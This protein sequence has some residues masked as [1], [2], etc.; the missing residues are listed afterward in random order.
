MKI[1]VQAG[2][3]GTRMKHLAETKPKSLIAAKYLPIVFH[4]FERFRGDEFV[5]VGDYKFD[6]FDNYLATFAENVKCILVKAQTKGNAA[7]LKEAVALVPPN[8]PFMVI[9]SDIIL[10][11][12]FTVRDIKKGCQVGVADFPCSWSLIDGR[13][14]HEQH[15]SKGVAGLYLFDDKGWFDDFPDGG[16]FTDW[17]ANK[18]IPLS[19]LSL[20]GSIDV[21]TLE[22]YKA[23]DT[24]ANRCRPYNRI[25]FADGRVIKTGLTPEADRLIKAEVAWYARMRD[26]GF[27]NV[28]LLYD[29][30]PLTMARIEGESVFAA[31]RDAGGR[32]VA[33]DRIVDALGGLHGGE[34]CASSPWDVYQEYDTKTLK[35]LHGVARAIPFALDPAITINGVACTNVLRAPHRLR[36]AVQDHLIDTRYTPIHG[37]CQLT[38]I[39]ISGDGRIT[40]IDPRGYFGGSAVLGDVRY[41]W[42]KLYF[43][44]EGNF[45]QFN[46]KNYELSIDERGVSYTI[47]SNGW[48]HLTGE[49]LARIPLGQGNAAQIELIHAVIWL[50][51]ASHAWEDFDSMCIA[52]YNGTLLLQRWMEEHGDARS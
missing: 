2:G 43:S 45:D 12:R 34:D 4:L 14:V 10:S 47:G 41:D 46:I 3:L 30:A 26:Y 15:A 17:L 5:I 49:L 50:S 39:M 51:M 36:R 19:P 6:V 22:A 20:M 27:A 23:I 7:G 9:W 24:A 35:R 33:R 18:D 31:L 44:V 8:E 13:L 37:D 42:A 40:F 1:I 48:E 21:G 25:S 38:N 29:T 11:E 16:S 28:P 32:A 52:F